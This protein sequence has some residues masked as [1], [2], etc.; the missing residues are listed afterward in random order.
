LVCSHIGKRRSSSP[1]IHCS[2]DKVR[3]IVGLYLNPL[4]IPAKL[5]DE[6]DDVDRAVSCG[7]WSQI[8]AQSVIIVVNF[9]VSRVDAP[10]RGSQEARQALARRWPVIEYLRFDAR[11]LGF[12]SCGRGAVGNAPWRGLRSR[13]SRSFFGGLFAQ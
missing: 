4:R 13:F 8:L 1:P 6:S 2:I 7:A 12:A 3:D 11:A 10:Q 9:R 5:T